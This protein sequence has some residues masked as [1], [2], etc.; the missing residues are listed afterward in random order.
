MGVDNKSR[1]DEY[2]NV[3]N[4]DNSNSHGRLGHLN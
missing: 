3:L 2:Y 1:T 4:Y